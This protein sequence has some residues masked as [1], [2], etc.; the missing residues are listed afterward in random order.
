MSPDLDGAALI[1]RLATEQRRLFYRDQTPRSL[2]E[3]GRWARGFDPSVVVE[4]GTLSGLSLRA[5]LAA[6]PGARIAAIDLSFEALHR[7]RSQA[8]L[9]LSRVTLIEQEICSVE[10]ARLWGPEDRVLLF[11]DAHD[12][13]EASIMSHVLE[14]AWPALPAGSL[15]IVDDLWFSPTPLGEG[16]TRE[17]V[18]RRLVH[19]I[20]PL[21]GFEGAHA[22]YHA[23]GAFVGFREVVPLLRWANCRHLA[24]EHVAGGKA[25]ALVKAASSEPVTAATATGAIRYHPFGPCGL[26]PLA[27]ELAAGPAA[28]LCA[29]ATSAFT[30]G[31]IREAGAL[32][33]QALRLAP[34]SPELALALAICRCREGE[35]EAALP[36]LERAG[37]LPFAEVLREAVRSRLEPPPIA[38]P[39]APALPPLAP[40]EE[41]PSLTLF[42]LP[43]AFRGHTALIQR[44]A[45]RSWTLLQPRPE[46]LLLGDEEGTAELAR[47]LGCRHLPEVE[48]TASGVPRVDRIFALAE[49]HGRHAFLA[50]VNADIVLGDDFT[51]AFARTRAEL[52]EFLMVGRRWDVALEAPIDFAEPG[53]HRSLCERV[54]REGVLHAVT[55]IDYFVFP[56]GFYGAD[57]PAFA[58]GRTAWDNWLVY[59]PVSRGKPVVDATEA[60][61]AIHQNHDYGHA[62]GVDAVFSG[63]DAARN[64]KLAGPLAGCGFC[65]FTSNATWEL[66]ASA[67]Q[68]RPLDG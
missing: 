57:L 47:E 34:G 27:P 13:R 67:L 58:I 45:I 43:K 46:I 41:P 40:R 36:L 32:L 21:Q 20:D 10:L 54:R 15:L 30:S 6:A 17:F 37:S 28:A 24:L 50:Y 56:K 18:E 61:F 11:V 16:R 59:H 49:A 29:R 42:A 51:A 23:G 9:D 63:P 31:A 64:R 26:A 3:L 25:V 65:G 60:V 52:E 19:E 5:W 44:N 33:E 2:A 55:G 4:L 22:S 7:S 1:E 53:W 14:H 39:E 66:T 38:A 62:G 8:P 68:Q 35:L 12:S 48:R